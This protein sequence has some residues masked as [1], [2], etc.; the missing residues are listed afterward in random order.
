ME[1][2]VVMLTHLS[3]RY[4]PRR[5]IRLHLQT[6]AGTIMTSAVSTEHWCTTAPHQ[7]V[8]WALTGGAAVFAACKAGQV[9]QE[10]WRRRPKSITLR[11][12]R[13]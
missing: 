3:Y 13:S 2:P 7:P 8:H 4:G 9:A 11:Y 5:Q 10:C 6:A 1:N 12:E